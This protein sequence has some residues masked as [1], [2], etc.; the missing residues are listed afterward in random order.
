MCSLA[1]ASPTIASSPGYTCETTALNITRAAKASWH[2]RFI[3]EK[4][5]HITVNKV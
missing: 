5:V 1:Q 4:T 3:L 2:L